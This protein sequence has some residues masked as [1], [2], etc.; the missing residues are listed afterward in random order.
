MGR[1]FSSLFLTFGI[2]VSLHLGAS[3]W[4]A[5]ADRE[6]GVGKVL[7]STSDFEF[8]SGYQKLSDSERSELVSVVSTESPAW[9]ALKNFS[10]AYFSADNVKDSW[11]TWFQEPKGSGE[12]GAL[13]D[14]K[15]LEIEKIPGP[16]KIKFQKVKCIETQ[17]TQRTPWSGWEWVSRAHAE[18]SGETQASVVMP[19]SL[20][21]SER[22]S[23]FWCKAK[24]L[25]SA[26]K[27]LPA[28]DSDVE[29]KT[30]GSAKA[31]DPVAAATSAS[32]STSQSKDSKNR[33]DCAREVQISLMMDPKDGSALVEE[34]LVSTNTTALLEKK[35][36]S[37]WN[38][39]TRKLWEAEERILS[40]ADAY[41]GNLAQRMRVV[42]FFS[43]PV[44]QSHFLRARKL[45]LFLR[46]AQNSKLL[47]AE[48]QPCD[49]L[50]DFYGKWVEKPTEQDSL[51]CTHLADVVKNPGRSV[52]SIEF[53]LGKPLFANGECKLY[54]A[55]LTAMAQK[56]LQWISREKGLDDTRL[57]DVEDTLKT[58]ASSSF[59]DAL[60]TKRSEAAEAHQEFD[61]KG[62]SASAV[63]A[64]L[65]T[66]QGR[67]K[68]EMERK[69]LSR[70][71]TLLSGLR[72][73]T[74]S[75]SPSAAGD[76]ETSNLLQS[77]LEASEALLTEIERRLE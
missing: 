36:R 22:M 49:L 52:A 1:T 25:W 51:S 75:L 55:R 42:E 8:V 26:E 45:A 32:Q 56:A 17:T 40:R 65:S 58:G 14:Q 47:R 5:D 10:N 71:V 4:G 77:H 46:L 69:D 67:Q 11:V 20:D 44:D 35:A 53:H 41:K 15:Y 27:C 18:G 59:M 74:A 60:L 54:H 73:Q 7:A 9:N 31:S 3:A 16:T 61:L 28:L 13:N 66:A 70:I 57:R 19:S 34:K 68:L 24:S 72:A 38:D 23:R 48:T 43:G 2:F 64:T 12:A 63:V 39:F 21:M 50:S 29:T 37:S 62:E 6:T 76:F 33:A 30:P